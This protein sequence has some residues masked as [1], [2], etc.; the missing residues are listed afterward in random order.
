MFILF[1]FVIHNPAHVETDTNLRLLDT[2]AGYYGRL[3]YATGGSFPS[4]IMS[5]F[6]HIAADFVR[7]TRAENN[8]LASAS[9]TAS[10]IVPI[11]TEMSMP[12]PIPWDAPI[13]EDAHQS[14]AI[15]SGQAYCVQTGISA[16][17]LFYPV[18]EGDAMMSDDLLAGFNFTNF[19]D[20]TLP[21][22]APQG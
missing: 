4:M 6:A 22:F 12:A 8:K 3:Q 18:V 10:R 15:G 1:D 13:S 5:G 9:G 7:R 20:T 19:F 16:E 14:N 21:D 11:L 2:A 17:P